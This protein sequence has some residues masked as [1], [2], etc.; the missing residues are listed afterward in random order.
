[1]D[2]Y[3]GYSRAT[4]WILLK[5]FQK[6]LH[7]LFVYERM[8]ASALVVYFLV[9]CGVSLTHCCVL[10][11]S[12]FLGSTFLI[13]VPL[14]H[15]REWCG[16]M[17]TTSPRPAEDAA[18]G[19]GHAAPNKKVDHERTC[20]HSLINEEKMQHFL[21]KF[22]EYPECSTAVAI[23][24]VHS[25]KGLDKYVRMKDSLK[26]KGLCC[27]LRKKFCKVAWRL[28]WKNNLPPSI[29]EYEVWDILFHLIAYD[30][31]LNSP[32]K[33]KKLPGADPFIKF[34]EKVD[35]KDLHQNLRMLT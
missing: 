10:G 25:T 22:Q 27:I 16:T 30:L 19:Q 21:E 2:N 26:N 24:I 8:A 7:L 29:M 5:F 14:P 31:F 17:P 20:C 23:I 28:M 9:G 33:K 15:F 1:M 13:R 4:F 6:M 11:W 34:I 3:D 32:S 18:V 12:G 35:E